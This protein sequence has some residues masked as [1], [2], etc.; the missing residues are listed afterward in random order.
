MHT[1]ISHSE[2]CRLIDWVSDNVGPFQVMG[3]Y[4][5]SYAE[6]Q[7]DRAAGTPKCFGGGSRNTMFAARDMMEAQVIWNYRIWHDSMHLRY[8]LDFSL[9]SEL[10]LS[11]LLEQEAYGELHWSYHS[12]RLVGLDLRLPIMQ[13]HLWKQHLMISAVCWNTL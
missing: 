4:N 10:K 6:L 11:F 2:A 9:E 12:A 5:P 1:I 13:Y 3:K 8:N 7:A